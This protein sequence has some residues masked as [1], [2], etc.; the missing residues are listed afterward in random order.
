MPSAQLELCHAYAR[1]ISALDMATLRAICASDMTL[2]FLPSS[3]GVPKVED[4]VAFLGAVQ[5]VF[6][7]TSELEYVIDESEVTESEGRVWFFLRAQLSS[8]SSPL[9]I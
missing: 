4:I 7:G 3:F 9:H 2:T 6:A 1:A 8:F 5:H